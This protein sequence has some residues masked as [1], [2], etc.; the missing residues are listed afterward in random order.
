MYVFVFR[1]FASSPVSIPVSIEALTGSSP[2]QSPSSFSSTSSSLLSSSPSSVPSVTVATGA[3]A[4]AESFR[5]CR[6]FLGLQTSTE[7]RREESCRSPLSRGSSLSPSTGTSFDLFGSSSTSSSPRRSSSSSLLLSSTLSPAS[8]TSS[9]RKSV[10]SPIHQTPLH[11]D[12]DVIGQRLIPVPTHTFKIILAVG[13]R[14]D[15]LE[16]D[17]IQR[18]VKDQREEGKD[19]T[20]SIFSNRFF[21]FGWK[22]RQIEEKTRTSTSISDMSL[23]ESDDDKKNK[24]IFSAVSSDESREAPTPS[25]SGEI[26]PEKM[27]G[28]RTRRGRKTE[29]RIREESIHEKRVLPEVLFGSFILPNRKVIGGG[30]NVDLSAYRVPLQFIEWTSGLD[31]QVRSTSP[32][33]HT[34]M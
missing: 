30:K 11:V 18:V 9:A 15:L 14:K 32:V 10:A 1:P 3:D 19:G 23:K 7:S 26:T 29:E 4:Y 12:Y 2:S 24:M 16:A 21:S 34:H 6:T 22:G 8:E 33:A 5:L 31:F 28:R 25:S 13:L 17:T 27:I 20:S